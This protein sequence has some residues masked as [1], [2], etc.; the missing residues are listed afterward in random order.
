MTEQTPEQNTTTTDAATPQGDGDKTAAPPW[1]DDF[2][3]ARAW[4][5]IQTLREREKEL[6][7]VTPI[8][9]E[10][11]QQLNEYNRLVE[12]SKTELER[13]QEELN[14]WQNEATRW[15]DTSVTSKI[16]ALAANDFVIPSDAV[17]K[18]TPANYIDAGGTID[19]AAIKRDLAKILDERPHWRRQTEPAKRVPAP[20]PGQGS[21]GGGNAPSDPRAE[22]AAILQGRR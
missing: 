20:N 16:E 11:K 19:E 18:L 4:H 12:A 15:R 17:D 3:P 8:T 14:R 10:Q 13:S 21:G 1:G 22:F 6:S 7:K 9:D 2:D 5:T